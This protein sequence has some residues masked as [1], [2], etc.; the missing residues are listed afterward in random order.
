M[1]MYGKYYKCVAITKKENFSS[2]DESYSEKQL[3]NLSTSCISISHRIRDEIIRIGHFQK[4]PG[5]NGNNVYA[6]FWRDKQ[7]VLWYF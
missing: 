6:K 4:V 3:F 1:Y 5:G 7:R 2:I